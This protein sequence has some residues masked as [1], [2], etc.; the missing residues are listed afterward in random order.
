MKKKF[1]L[2]GVI[3]LSCVICFCCIKAKGEKMPPVQFSEKYFI[4]ADMNNGHDG[5]PSLHE[6]W[7]DGY[8]IICY[9][10]TVEVYLPESANSS[11][12]ELR[13][14]FKLTDEK[15][16]TLV[17]NIDVNELYNLD[18]M[19]DVG[20]CDCDSIY[21]N[22]YDNNDKLVKRCGS[23]APQNP[24]MNRILNLVEENLDYKALADIINDWEQEVCGDIEEY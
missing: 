11:S 8:Y 9:D 3:V 12:A 19:E 15:I 16:N 6:P 21:F 5:G 20:S 7:E 2:I 4:G 14:T 1:I 10:G 17:S 18:P 22:V 24:E 13:A 23:Y